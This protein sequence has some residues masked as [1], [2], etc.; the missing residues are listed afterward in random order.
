M[1]NSK[2]DFIDR[3]KEYI[4]ILGIDKSPHTISLYLASLDQFFDFMDVKSFDDIAQ[5][6]AGDMRNYQARLK[7][8]GSQTSSINVYVQ[9]IK[10]FFNW[11]LENEYIDTYPF[12]AVKR[13]KETKK[14]LAFL[15]EAEI[16]AMFRACKN[17]EE[18][19]ILST[20]IYL[21]LRRSE[22]VNL[23]L[24]DIEG[25]RVSII[26][27]GSK[28]R[29]LFLPENALNILN[30]YIASN[31][32]RQSEYVFPSPRGG[33]YTTEAIRLKINRIAISAGF[34]E[35]RVDQIT[36]HVMRRTFAT[37]LVENGVNMGVIQR[38]MGHSSIDTTMRYAKIRDTAVE[39]V[40]TNQKD[41]MSES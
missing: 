21:G 32:D 3:V 15:S 11:L 1:T 14:N 40:M 18:T 13:L 12:G 31:K 23:K 35:A 2:Y 6:N 33:G 10:V 16:F 17:L 24:S 27:K 9:S 20:L 36:P 8:A 26:G 7:L 28:G 29:K 41:F 4:D 37:N 5:I 22:L 38:T 19:T 34:D 39:N 30:T 25:N